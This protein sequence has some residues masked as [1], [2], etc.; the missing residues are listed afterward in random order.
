MALFKT[1]PN[2][3]AADVDAAAA[4]YRDG[5]ERPG[6]VA[7]GESRARRRLERMRVS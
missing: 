1:I 3:G 2:L 6:R 5:S 7:R 4:F